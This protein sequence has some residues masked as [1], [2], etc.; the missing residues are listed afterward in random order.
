LESGIYDQWLAISESIETNYPNEKYIHQEYHR[1]GVLT[2][3]KTA[4]IFCLLSCVIIFAL[5]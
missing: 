2:L 3:S 4:G 1:F 5:F